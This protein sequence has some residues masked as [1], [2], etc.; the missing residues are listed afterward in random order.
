M[1]EDDSWNATLM[2]VSSSKIA[3]IATTVLAAI[4]VLISA[5][6]S[7]A[8]SQAE[9]TATLAQPAFEVASIRPVV[10]DG[11]ASMVTINF[12]GDRYIASN[13]TLQML[14]KEAYG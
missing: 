13:C 2:A 6:P 9:D 3:A 7:N 12:E 1:I 10:S 5:L 8:Q 11:F 14:I 4:F